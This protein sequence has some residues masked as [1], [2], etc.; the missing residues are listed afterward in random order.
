MVVYK[1]PPRP[2]FKATERG[3]NEQ[4]KEAPTARSDQAHRHT[5]HRRA[6][7][8][9]TKLGP[10]VCYQ[11]IPVAYA[12]KSKRGRRRPKCPRHGQSRRAPPPDGTLA[13]R[14][15]RAGYNALNPLPS[16][17]PPPGGAKNGENQRRGSANPQATRRKGGWVPGTPRLAVQRCATP[18]PRDEMRGRRQDFN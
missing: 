6:M 3:T 4:R 8:C 13:A 14:V 5:N 18:P 11:A 9:G 17:T 12:R 16:P 10:R 15:R 2:E 7:R 1:H